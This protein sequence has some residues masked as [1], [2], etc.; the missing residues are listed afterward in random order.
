MHFKYKI[1]LTKNCNKYEIDGIFIGENK[2]FLYVLIKHNPLT[3]F[4]NHNPNS[5]LIPGVIKN[6]L[7]LF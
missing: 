5:L 6:S 4:N 1:D 7:K 2:I 3:P